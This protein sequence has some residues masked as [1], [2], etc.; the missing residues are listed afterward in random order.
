MS[1]TGQDIVAGDITFH[2]RN[3]TELLRIANDGFY[4]RGVKVEQGHGEAQVVYAAFVEFLKG[5]I[6][7]EG[8]PPPFDGGKEN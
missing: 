6:W 3:G 7:M 1:I 8:A 2:P 4:V 5:T